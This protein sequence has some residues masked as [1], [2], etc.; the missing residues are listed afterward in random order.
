VD[1]Q[2]HAVAEPVAEVL[3]LPRVLDQL[4]RHRI[5]LTT[6]LAGPDR[7]E[8]RELRAQDELVDLAGTGLDRLA[9][10]IGPRAVRAVAVELCAP[11]D[12]HEHIG[13]DLDVARLG[14]RQGAV[15]PRGDDRGKARLLGAQPSHPRLELKCHIALGPPHEAFLERRPQRLVG[16]LAGRGDQPDLGRFLDGPQPLEEARA[17][18]ELPA[19]ADEL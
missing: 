5:D 18:D 9:G 14:V 8:A 19:L 13:G 11:V 1:L 7:L 15:G 4:A 10:G 17:A 12:R 6:A 16:E 2:A 3:P